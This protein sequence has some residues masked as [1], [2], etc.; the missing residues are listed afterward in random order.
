VRI[1]RPRG[2]LGREGREIEGERA[3]ERPVFGVDT[4]RVIMTGGEEYVA[5]DR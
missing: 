3:R 5:Q 1:G 4:E 2:R